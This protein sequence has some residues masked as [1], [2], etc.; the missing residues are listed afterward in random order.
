M[1]FIAHFIILACCLKWKIMAICR[2]LK[3]LGTCQGVETILR[4][5]IKT[6]A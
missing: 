2:N 5:K 6:S 1:F 3:N 4:G